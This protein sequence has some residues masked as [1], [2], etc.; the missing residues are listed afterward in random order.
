MNKLISKIVGVALGLALATGVGAGVVL[1]NNSVSKAD[2]AAVGGTDTIDS[3][4]VNLSNVN[5]TTWST[6]NIAALTSG[7]TYSYR[8]MGSKS[9]SDGRMGGTNGN[10]G[11][12]TTASG[13]TLSSVTVTTTTSKA[14][15]LYGGTAAFTA[16]NDTSGRT[17]VG[18][19]TTTGSGSTYSY[20]WSNLANNGF[21]HALVKGTASSTFIKSVVFVWNAPSSGAT[22]TLGSSTLSVATTTEK[23]LS[24]DYA[25]LTANITV[26]QTSSNGGAVTLSTDGETYSSSLTLDRTATAPQTVYV[27]G[28][29]AGTVS[30]SFASTG[31][32]TKTCTVDVS[33]P[34]VYKKI[35]S[36]ASMKNGGS[37]LL[38]ATGTQIA[39]S[40]NQLTN[41]RDPASVDVVSDDVHLP[42]T[43][44][45]A[46]LT[47]SQGTGTYANYYTI[48]DPAYSTNGGYLEYYNSNL[49]CYYVSSTPSTDAYYWSIS[50]NNGHVVLENKSNAGYYIEYNAASNAK[51]FRLYANTQTKLD[52]YELES[53]I[54]SSTALTSI[55][56]ENVSVGAGST[57][58]YTGSYAPANATEAIEATLNSAVATLSAVS[59]SNGTFTITI[60]AGSSA[61]SA[62]L[63][64]VGEDGH[65]STTVTLT[66]TAFTST[67]HLVYSAAALAN[68]S[69]VVIGSQSDADNTNYASAAHTGGDYMPVAPTAYSTDKTMLAAD[70]NTK[71]YTVWCVDSTNG[72]YVIA[73]D[74]YYLAAPTSAGNKLQRTDVLSSR[75]YFTITDDSENGILLTSQ[76]SVDNFADTYVL[77]YNYN[78][79]TNAR[80]ALYKEGTQTAA[81]LYLSND[82][83]DNVQGFIDVFM[84]MSNYSSEKG[85]C[86]DE[87]HHYFAD[88][89]AAFNGMGDVSR[90]SFCTNSAYAAAYARLCAWAAANGQTINSSNRIVEAASGNMMR[91]VEMNNNAL[92]IVVITA[93]VSATFIGGYFFLR[94]KKEN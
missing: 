64:L 85:Y 63:T 44:D 21:T 4:V 27:K 2:A 48:F 33:A 36:V 8:L 28:S 50:F 60:T 70:S 16:Y 86:S 82:S 40:K 23:A 38:V 75:N 88:A 90:Q 20:T 34:I 39:M 11:I 65:G 74:G 53:D 54:P 66:V 18:N 41:G 55:T 76:Y 47:I 72:Y 83:V 9:T 24:V 87:N 22:I 58:T 71:E 35:E 68:G 81:S 78:G 91:A 69:K 57:I 25:N 52:L 1:G 15:A 10:G 32:T 13:G 67:H 73:A 29:A 49:T 26:S 59:M 51:Y 80:F 43:T 3:S 42:A 79:G 77:R 46:V 62:T 84:H 92:I 94:K 17:S 37:F 89:K 56:A 7:A 14:L 6:G 45:A 5:N 19:G 31:A 61:G 12:W 93:F 30:L